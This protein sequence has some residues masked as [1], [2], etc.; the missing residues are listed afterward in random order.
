M[1]TSAKKNPDQAQASNRILLGTEI[2]GDI[3]TNGDLRVDGLVKGTI[4]AAGKLV[5]G[6]KGMVEGEVK[7]ANATVS[8]VIKG[9]LHIDQLLTMHATA[10]IKGDILTGKLSVEPGAEFT[11]KCSMGAVVRDL[12]EDEARKAKEKSA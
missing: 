1:I 6:E 8:G 10:K 3:K 4:E 11:G 2:V 7:C 12:V 5:V 9:T